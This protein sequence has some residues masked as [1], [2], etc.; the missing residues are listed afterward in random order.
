MISRDV[1]DNNLILV[2]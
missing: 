2:Y 1:D